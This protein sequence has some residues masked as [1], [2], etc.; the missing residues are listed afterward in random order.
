MAGSELLGKMND[1]LLRGVRR[2]SV[3]ENFFNLK[4][5]DIPLLKKSFVELLNFK[6]RLL[7]SLN[8]FQQDYFEIAL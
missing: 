3:L 2:K 1:S 7:N 8:Y 5:I 6:W 4:N